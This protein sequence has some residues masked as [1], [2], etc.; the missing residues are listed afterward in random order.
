LLLTQK[1]TSIALIHKDLH[2]R[3][4]KKIFNE[5]NHNK[6][7]YVVATDILARGIDIIGADVVISFSL[8]EDDIWYMHRIGRVGRNNTTGTS[9]V[10]YQR[11]VDNIINRL[12]NKKI[13]FHYYLL[14]DEKGLIAKPLKLRLQKKFI[15]DQKTNNEI[16]KIIR[17][18]SRHVQPGYKKKIASI[19]KKIK[20]K[21]RHEYIEKIIKRQLVQKNIID[22]KKK[23]LN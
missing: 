18:N 7:Q 5:I 6:Y 10:I 17:T 23:K 2:E 11:G 13:D 21:L 15:F 14:D 3:D 12:I 19:I 4:R 20:Q 8:P 16:K 22:S 9:F 1:I